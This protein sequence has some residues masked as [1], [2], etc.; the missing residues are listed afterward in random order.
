MNRLQPTTKD[1]HRQ[2]LLFYVVEETENPSTDYYIRPYLEHQ[3]ATYQVIKLGGALPDIAPDQTVSIIFVRYINTAWKRWVTRNRS[4]L[5]RVVLFIDDDILDWRVISHLP[6]GSHAK[7]ALQARRHKR[8]FRSNTSLWVSTRYLQHKYRAWN[9]QLIGLHCPFAKPAPITTDGAGALT[10]FYHGSYAHQAETDWLFDV[11]ARVLQQE[12]DI[13]FELTGFAATKK[14]FTGLRGVSIIDEMSWPDYR[15]FISTAG[16]SIGLAP[17]LDSEFNR[18][19]NHVK[20][21]DITQAG[22]AGIFADHPVFQGVI[23]HGQNGLLVPMH[24]ASWVD[25]ILR[26]AR[27]PGFRYRLA[28]SARQDFTSKQNRPVE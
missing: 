23:R 1:S 13:R 25:A 14:R 19:R 20:C 10:V 22:A 21:F 26:L 17:L 27:D 12:Q 6:I 28:K 11:V 18:A 5:D 2:D 4:R 7:Y 8:W 24:A 9:P 15:G 16:R 3:S